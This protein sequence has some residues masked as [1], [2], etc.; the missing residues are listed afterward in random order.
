MPSFVA[1]FHTCTCNDGERVHVHIYMIAVESRFIIFGMEIRHNVPE[2]PLL[3][4]D[5]IHSSKVVG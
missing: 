5:K 1:M 2:V 4:M 3:L